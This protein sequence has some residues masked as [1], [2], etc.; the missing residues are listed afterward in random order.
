M[1]NKKEDKGEGKEKKKKE[2]QGKRDVYQVIY[3]K[4][5]MFFS[6]TPANINNKYRN[7][8]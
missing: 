7:V 1:K 3:K 8:N 6:R 4:V 2:M 5:N